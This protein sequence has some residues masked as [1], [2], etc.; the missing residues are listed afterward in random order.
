AKKLAVKK[1]DMIVANDIT[2][3]GSGFASDTNQVT[4]IDKNG[5]TETLPLLPK[6]EVADKIL[7]RVA[8]LLA[9]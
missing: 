1:L 8:V 5:E 9:Q 7:S 4:I 2:S 6:R 3:S